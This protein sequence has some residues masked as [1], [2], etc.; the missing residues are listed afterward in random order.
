MRIMALCMFCIEHERAFL[1]RVQ[2]AAL[3]FIAL[4]IL[5][6]LMSR[7]ILW[8]FGCF[9]FRMWNWSRC[10]HIHAIDPCQWAD[11]SVA[12]H[13]DRFVHILFVL[14]LVSVSEQLASI[15]PTAENCSKLNAIHSM[16]RD[17]G[18]GK[19]DAPKQLPLSLGFKCA[20]CGSEFESRAGMAQHGRN[21]SFVG[22]PCADP[23]NSKSM[24]FTAPHR[25]AR[26]DHSAGILCQHNSLGV[27][28]CSENAHFT[29][30]EYWEWCTNCNNWNNS[31]NSVIIVY[32][33]K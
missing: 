24:S 20:H 31:H 21:S 14:C 32:N 13:R 6:S 33:S 3:H 30:W 19:P 25:S 10:M 5:F 23:R 17:A 8:H 12:M 28:F 22:T 18:R 15:G 1:V 2:S 29:Y 7:S 27:L 11:P 16:R 9:S 26:G 4:I